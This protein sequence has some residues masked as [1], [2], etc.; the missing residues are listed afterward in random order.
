MKLCMGLKHSKHTT[1][2]VFQTLFL[3]QC[4]IGGK[5]PI[6]FDRISAPYKLSYYTMVTCGQTNKNWNRRVLLIRIGLPVV[7]PSAT[8]PGVLILPFSA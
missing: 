7:C 3:F 5:P 6:I 1:G 2:K 4:I 8:Y